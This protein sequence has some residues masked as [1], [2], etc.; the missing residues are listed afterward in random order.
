MSS[1]VIVGSQWGDEGKGKMT[2]YLSQEADVVVRSQGGN[3]AGHTIAFDGKKFALRLVPSGI[4]AKDKLAVIGNGVVI[5]PPALLKELHYLQ[6]NGIDISGLRISSRSHITFPYHILLDKC[7]EEAKG[8]HK[9]GTTKNGI[10]PTYMDKVSRVGIRMCDL[11]EKDTFKEKLERNL[12]EK[13]ELFTKLYHVDPISFDD[14]FES[15]Y[16]YGQELKQYV[17]DTA[18]IVNDALD[19]DKKVLF[20]GAQGVMLDV[21]QGTYPYVTASNPIAG[22]VCTGV[23]VGPNKIETVVGICKAYSTRVGAGPFPT[24]LTDEIGDQIRETGHE[25]GTVTGRPRRVGWFDSVAMR[26]AR[27]V[28]GIS[29][30]SLNLLDVLT[31]LKTVK[32]CTSYKLDGKQIDYYPASLKELERCEPVYEEL[33][34]WDEDITGAKKFEDLPINA[35]NYLKRVSELSESPLATVSVGADRIQTIIVKDP[36]E[37]AHK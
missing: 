36:W 28:S 3:N 16:E 14:I 6:D 23:G 34:G 31:G 1:V 18:Q 17:T 24:E 30:L 9:V 20:E 5:N 26:H 22:G 2:D 32:I 33:P 35:Q 10:G 25:Y 21:D 4:F 11:L 7:Q 19:Q 13:N 15:Y 37:F 29:C 12:A 8:D 27:R